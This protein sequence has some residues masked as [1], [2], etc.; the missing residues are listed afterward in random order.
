MKIVLSGVLCV[1]LMVPGVLMANS[2]QQKCSLCHGADGVSKM[3]GIPSLAE[4]KLSAEE[5]VAIIENGRG[6]MPKINVDA[7]QK[8]EIVDY[9]I[10]QIKK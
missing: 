2:F 3:P 4:T 7:D 9:V 10:K 1:M 8:H 6:K 5:I